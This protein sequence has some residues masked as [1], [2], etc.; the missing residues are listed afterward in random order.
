MRKKSYGHINR[1]GK[2]FDNIQLLLMI[3]VLKKL[4]YG[5]LLP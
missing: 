3:K 4:R 1:S 5:R 2:A